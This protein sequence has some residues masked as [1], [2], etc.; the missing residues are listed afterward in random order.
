MPAASITALRYTT[1]PTVPPAAA[2]QALRYTIPTAPAP[3]A[4]ITAL[5]YVL[6]TPPT[7]QAQIIA[8][9]YTTAPTPPPTET[10][11][12]KGKVSGILGPVANATITLNGHFATTLQDGSYR[13][14]GI[15]L[16][17]YTLNAAAPFPFNYIYKPIAQTVELKQA[18]IEYTKDIYM[19]LNIINIGAVAGGLIAFISLCIMAVKGG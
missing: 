16:G 12:L 14:E 7:A 15:P 11:T 8:L 17:S 19:P 4:S 9:R 1:Q 5:R 13:I 3:A 2:I 18:G 6:P 10:A